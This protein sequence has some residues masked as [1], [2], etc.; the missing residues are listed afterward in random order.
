MF[1]NNFFNYIDQSNQSTL[2]SREITKEF[3]KYIFLQDDIGK[4]L[5]DTRSYPASIEPFLIWKVFLFFCLARG[6]HFFCLALL[7]S[8]GQASIS[9]HPMPSWLTN[10][11]FFLPCPGV[12]FFLPCPLFGTWGPLDPKVP[13]STQKY[14]SVFL[15]IKHLLIF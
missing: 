9:A 5:N 2:R 7:L 15:Q 14:T 11:V 6:V 13:P 10:C 3:A 1:Y 4:Q 8:T 12:S